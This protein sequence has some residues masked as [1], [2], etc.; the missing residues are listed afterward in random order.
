MPR[1]VSS[2]APAPLLGGRLGLSRGRRHALGIGR[3]LVDASRHLLGAT[4]RGADR[5]SVLVGAGRRLLH[6]RRD[7]LNSQG[8]LVGGLAK[9]PGQVGDSVGAGP[10][11]AGQLA[12]PADHPAEGLAQR[13]LAGLRFD[14]VG[15]VAFGD[16]LGDDYHAPL[17]DDHL[18]ERFA[19]LT[20]LVLRPHLDLLVEVALRETPRRHGDLLDP[21]LTPRA[22]STM[23][24]D[25]TNSPSTAATIAFRRKSSAAASNVVDGSAAT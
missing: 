16:C 15:K 21:R 23:T 19:H 5:E 14:V 24:T 9:L 13:V 7:V 25:V 10:D 2:T 4:A 22:K 6:R 17:V 12:E 18:T 20:D 3:D 8:G 11:C 1:T